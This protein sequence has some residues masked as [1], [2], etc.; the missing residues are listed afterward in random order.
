MYEWRVFS[1]KNLET[2][3][4]VSLNFEIAPTEKRKDYYYDFGNEMYGLKERIG[5]AETDFR[6]RL[7]LKVMLDREENG[8]EYWVK[9]ISREFPYHQQKHLPFYQIEDLIEDEQKESSPFRPYIEGF[10]K[11]LDGDF[12]IVKVKKHRKKLSM[13][14]NEQLVNVELV[15]GKFLGEKFFGL[16]IESED[17]EIISELIHEWKLNEL[18]PDTGYPGF[19][20]NI[21]ILAKSHLSH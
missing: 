5:D 2:Y 21:N 9:A 3:L 8:S 7:E 16:T 15:K 13:W 14:Y 1:E 18:E 6:P 10:Q 20:S 19:I 4:P 11:V 12:E 17:N